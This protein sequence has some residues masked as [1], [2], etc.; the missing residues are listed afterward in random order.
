MWNVLNYAAPTSVTATGTTAVTATLAAV[1]GL[2]YYITDISCSA[3]HTG[4]SF[5]LN[6]GA[7]VMWQDL[8]F[9][10]TTP[11]GSPMYTMNFNAPIK[12]TVGS[13]C[14]LV[15]T[16]TSGSVCNANIAGFAK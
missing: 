3:D 10:G 6:N 12:C 7:T 15:V 5:V 9:T 4:A 2:I 13:A 1:S 11:A 16:N 8:I 14:T